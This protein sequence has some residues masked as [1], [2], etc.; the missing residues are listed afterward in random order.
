MLAY[1]DTAFLMSLYGRDANSPSARKIASSQPVFLLTPLG[2]TEF[3]NAVESLVFRSYWSRTD[4]DAILDHFSRQRTVGVFRSVPLD[5]DVWDKAL[6]FSRSHTASIGTRTIDILHVA[7]A[8]VL[9]PDAFL[10]FDKRQ[11]KLAR[12]VGLR[13][14]PA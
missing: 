11:A 7:T 9:K 3:I 4:A 14:L 13:V 8:V 10:T 1:A 5:A 2:E 12:A 6:D